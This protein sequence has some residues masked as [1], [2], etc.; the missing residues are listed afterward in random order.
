MNPEPGIKISD[1]EPGQESNHHD[2]RVLHRGR[3]PTLRVA[4]PSCPPRLSLPTV[5]SRLVHPPVVEV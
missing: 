2:H 4:W 3:E 5:M 1:I